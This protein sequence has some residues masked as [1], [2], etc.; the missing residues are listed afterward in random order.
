VE[1]ASYGL[2]L[3]AECSLVSDLTDRAVDVSRRVNR[4]GRRQTHRALRTLSPAALRTRWQRAARRRGPDAPPR[5]LHELLP[6]A[7]GPKTSG[8]ARVHDFLAVDV[9]TRS[10][11]APR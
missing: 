8:Y 10:V 2:T 7:F 9:I 11:R 6:D 4:R 1:N 3:C 5:H